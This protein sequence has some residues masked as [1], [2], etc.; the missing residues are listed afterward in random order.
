[1]SFF[2]YWFGFSLSPCLVRSLTFGVL[3]RYE[4]YHLSV[5]VCWKVLFGFCGRCSFTFIWIEGTILF[6]ETSGT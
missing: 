1:M 2:F 5:A 3:L 6:P 4:V